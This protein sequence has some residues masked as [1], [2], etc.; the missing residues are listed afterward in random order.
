MQ[1]ISELNPDSHEDITLTSVLMVPVW[2][3]LC[4]NHIL[5]F[6]FFQP[7]RYLLAF[8]LVCLL[9]TYSFE[10]G[11]RYS[12]PLTRFT[13]MFAFAVFTGSVVMAFASRPVISAFTKE[14]SL[15]ET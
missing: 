5:C 14:P 1:L 2:L 9:L 7:S 3:I 8:C 10:G 12:T 11:I 13:D 6:F 15:L 4:V